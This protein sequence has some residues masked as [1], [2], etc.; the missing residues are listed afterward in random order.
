MSPFM[1]ILFHFKEFFMEN[2]VFAIFDN[3]TGSCMTISASPTPQSFVRE[4]IKFITSV[5]PL[6]DLDFYEIGTINNQ[7]LELVPYSEKI[8][9]SWDC[10]KVPMSK[11][12]SLAP[13]N[14][15]KEEFNACV[16]MEN[17][18]DADNVSKE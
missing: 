14:I 9:R 10:Y 2:K 16:R 12:E 18:S 17:D 6:R 3:V 15:P 11:A 8:L 1:V 13:L 4:N 7:T 5:R